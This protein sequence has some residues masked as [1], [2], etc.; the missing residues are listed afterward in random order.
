MFFKSTPNVYDSHLKQFRH[1]NY[2]SF[3][4]PVYSIWGENELGE[5]GTQKDGDK[6]LQ[7]HSQE[8]GI[9]SAKLIEGVEM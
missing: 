2:S 7:C 6:E 9:N 8:L 3:R 5:Q 4:C 1:T